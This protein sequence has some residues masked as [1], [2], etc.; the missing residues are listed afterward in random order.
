MGHRP[1]YEWFFH[2]KLNLHFK[3]EPLYQGRRTRIDHWATST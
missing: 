1:I 2:I 3:K